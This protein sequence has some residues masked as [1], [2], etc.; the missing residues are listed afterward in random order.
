MGDEEILDFESYAQSEQYLADKTVFNDWKTRVYVNGEQLGV[1]FDQA[2]QDIANAAAVR[3]NTFQEYN[4]AQTQ[5]LTADLNASLAY[6]KL[7]ALWSTNDRSVG[8]LSNSIKS[9]TLN[10]SSDLIKDFREQWQYNFETMLGPTNPLF[11]DAERG[12]SNQYGVIVAV[13]DFG[14]PTYEEQ[15]RTIEQ[16][17]F[18]NNV[19]ERTGLEFQQVGRPERRVQLASR[20][21]GGAGQDLRSI[22]GR[23]GD[24]NQTAQYYLANLGFNIGKDSSGNPIIDGD[25]GVMSS[26]SLILFQYKTGLS[27]T[28]RADN[29]TLAALADYA[30]K[31]LTYGDIMKMPDREMVLR[32]VGENGRLDPNTLTRIPAIGGQDAVLYQSAAVAWARMVQAAGQETTGLNLNAFLVRG[33]ISGYRDYQ[34]QV[35]MWEYW[36]KDRTYAAVPGTS[37]HG[38]GIAADLNISDPR[39]GIAQ[40][41]ELKWI[42]KNAGRFGFKPYIE[43]VVNGA[44]VYVETWHWELK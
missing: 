24:V 17:E 13:D 33:T 20:D 35:E 27:I 44:N 25:L 38:W 9:D 32:P 11:V 21:V 42:E 37:N 22:L 5:M 30:Q 40:S 10:I 28:G 34:G 8:T 41:S 15:I 3:L 4:N 7:P 18:L 43:D 16:G 29:T 31:G 39:S 1:H 19:T 36:G 2:Y 26:S 6:S 14:N 23:L 12:I